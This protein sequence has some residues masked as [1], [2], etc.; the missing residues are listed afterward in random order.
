[1]RWLLLLLGITFGAL[2]AASAQVRIHDVGVRMLAKP[3][4]IEK[5]I[6]LESIDGLYCN[7]SDTKRLVFTLR[8]S[9]V[10]EVVLKKPEFSFDVVLRDGSW[11]SLG[12][13]KGCQITFPQTG[14]SNR[15]SRT[16]TAEFHSKLTRSDLESYLRQS[17]GSSTLVRL[18]GKA[19]LVVRDQSRTDFSKKNVKLELSGPMNFSK[20]FKSVSVGLG[21]S[22]PKPGRRTP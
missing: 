5:R 11:A 7:G 20:G 1:M 16:Y 9:G 22:L 13:L 14:G 8:N 12:T 21:N 6:E 19:E 15:T 17:A 10:K 3:F 4:G 2:G 18:L